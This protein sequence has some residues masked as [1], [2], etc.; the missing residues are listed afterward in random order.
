MSFP[1]SPTNGQTA[2][3]SGIDYQYNSTLGTWS[4][5]VQ[6]GATAGTFNTLAANAIT[7]NGASVVSVSSGTGNLT[8]SGNTITLSAMGPGATTTGSATAIPVITTDAYGR[9]SAITTASPSLTVNLSG[10]S[11]S[12]S[13]AA[14]GGT[15]TF[16]G[17][18]GFGAS[19]SGS[20]V[21]LS[22]PQNLQ[23]SAT[24]TF[25]NLVISGSTTPQFP[26]LNATGTVSANLV[27]V[28]YSTLGT[29]TATSLN[30]TSS[31]TVGGASVLT[32]SA[33]GSTVPGPTGAGA[34]GSWGISVTGSAASAT[35]ATNC[36]SATYA[37]YL[38]NS[39]AYTNGTDGW[40]R[41]AGAC[42]WYNASYAVGIYSTSSGL[43]QTYNSSSFQVNGALYATSSV[44]AYY[45]DERLK[46][47]VGKI[48]NALDKVDQLSGFLYVENDLAKSLGFKN[49]Q[50]QVALSA[51][52]VQ[53]I[54]PEA[55]ALAPFDRET[56]GTSKSGENYLTVQYE[57][58]VPLLVEAIKELRAEVNTIKAQ[59]KG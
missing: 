45:S 12:G 54:Q 14:N 52:A 11:G 27:S 19:V 31:L 1:S 13:V 58:L 39:N 51:Q 38:N 55:V 59:L 18:N 25:A 36:T 10:T 35:N 37:G 32:S 8:I 17:S 9:I 22:D 47:K 29:A 44:T 24:P 7:V 56:D 28:S 15:L 3:V 21:T 26:A 46:T 4:R 42:G 23:T 30:A 34:S 2:I 53:R 20:T 57:R 33:I 40:F 5:L 6:G 43:V 41:S 49:E 50:Q 48:E 16:A